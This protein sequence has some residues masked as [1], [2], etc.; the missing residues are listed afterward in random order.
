MS[1]QHEE[2][3]L[4]FMGK[5]TQTL[6]QTTEISYQTA[7]G[8]NGK[9]LHRAFQTETGISDVVVFINLLTVRQFFVS[10]FTRNSS[11]CCSAS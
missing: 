5:N 8:R 11:Y 2:D 7:S 6:L 1:R 4:V 3:Q 9:S 10:V